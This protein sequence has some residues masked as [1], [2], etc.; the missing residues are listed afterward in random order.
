MEAAGL[1]PGAP[2]FHCIR[3]VT[4]TASENLPLDFN[5]LR[6]RSG[7]FSR[8]R[9]VRQAC[10]APFRVFPEL[11]RLERRCASAAYALGNFIAD[12]QF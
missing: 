4:D 12:C 1:F 5:L 6:D 3:V 9:I 10:R 11:I 8:T 2:R 7:R